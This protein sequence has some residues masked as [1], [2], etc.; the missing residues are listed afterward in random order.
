MRINID[1][2]ICPLIVLADSDRFA[3]IK[4][5]SKIIDLFYYLRCKFLQR[6]VEAKSDL[7]L[8]GALFSFP[9]RIQNLRGEHY[10]ELSVL[11]LLTQP[12][13]HAGGRQM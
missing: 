2:I 6:N 13:A 5:K 12:Y 8:S 3:E 1:D 11:F 9:T 4:N 7:A 10:W